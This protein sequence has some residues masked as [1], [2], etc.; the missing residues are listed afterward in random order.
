MESNVGGFLNGREEE[1]QLV[2]KEQVMD[3]SAP[4]VALRRFTYDPSHARTLLFLR[5]TTTTHGNMI[6][7]QPAIL[8]EFR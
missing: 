8:S 7:S 2:Q 3:K 1:S 5:C 4:Q 6:A